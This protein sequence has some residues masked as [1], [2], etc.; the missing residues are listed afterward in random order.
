M[1]AHTRH[2]YPCGDDNAINSASSA[3][4]NGNL[5]GEGRIPHLF[6]LASSLFARSVRTNSLQDLEDA[7]A[8][9]RGAVAQYPSPDS[10]SSLLLYILAECLLFRFEILNNSSDLQEGLSLHRQTLALRPSNHAAHYRSQ[11]SLA[12]AL[13][14][15][16]NH[17]GDYPRLV[18]A[19]D[20]GCAALSLFD[21]L[22]H[23]RP[24]V[25]D[26]IAKTF[27]SRFN[28]VGQPPDLPAQDDAPPPLPPSKAEKEWKRQK[29]VEKVE[30]ESIDAIMEMTGLEE[31]KAQVLRIKAKIDTAERQGVSMSDEQFNIVLRGNPGTGKTTIARHYARFLASVGILSED[32]FFETTGSRLAND[33]VRGIKDQLEEMLADDGGAV[34]IDEAYQLTNG[35]SAGGRQVL[36]FLLAEME[37]HIGKLVFIFAGYNKQMETFFEHNPGLASRVPYSLQFADYTDA[38]LLHMLAKLIAKRYNGR[39]VI[40]GGTYGLY[41]RIAVRRLGRGRGTEGFGNARALRTMFAKICER[42][43]MRL[44]EMRQTGAKPDDFLF[45]KEDIIGPDPSEALLESASWRKLH[46]LVGL[47]EV[48]QN[49][50]NLFE[51]I[52]E[53]YKRELAEKKPIQMSLNRVF[54]GNPGTGKTTVAKLYGQIL[55]DIGLLSNGEVVLKNPAD[56]IGSALGESEKNTKAILAAT[57][58][59]VLVIDE[60]YSLYGNSAGD[61]SRPSDDYRTSVIDVLVAQIQSVPGEDR[62]VLMCGYEAQMRTMFQNVNPGLSGRFAIEDAFRFEDYTD[63]ELLQIMD[64]KLQEQDLDASDDAKKVALDMLGRARNRPNFGNGREVENI[65]GKAKNNYRSRVSTFPASQRPFDVVFESADFDPNFDRAD[66]SDASLQRLFN[67]MIGVETIVEKLREYQAIPRV[68]KQR[69]QDSRQLIPTNFIFKGPPGSGKTTVARRMGQVY[70][71]MGFLSSAELIECSV[72]DLAGQ[73]V[74]HTGP[75]AKQVF[76]RA[77]GKVLLIDD[78]HRFTDSAYCQEAMNELVS[79]LGQS[80]QLV[81]ILAGDGKKMDA[82]LSANSTLANRVQETIHFPPFSPE[83]C[84]EI[85]RKDL[86]KNNIECAALDATGSDE[87]QYMASQIA[88]LSAQP[89]WSN[90]HDL[91]ALSQKLIR[92]TFKQAA[93]V[94]GEGDNL[95]LS[96]AGAA[97]CIAD[98][99]SERAPRPPSPPPTSTSTRRRGHFSVRAFEMEL[100]VGGSSPSSPSPVPASQPETYQAQAEASFEASATRHQEQQRKRSR[101]MAMEDEQSHQETGL[102]DTAKEQRAQKKLKEMALCP[103]GFEWTKEG[104]GYRCKGGS[105]FVSNAQLGM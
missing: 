65:L 30:S 48:K 59:K 55:A 71:D 46:Q 11:V 50:Q 80:T 42:Q 99:V 7:I 84:L 44:A 70:Y 21:P 51:L 61:G 14:T 12:K 28:S 45:T 60:A 68:S 90:G 89:S 18:E 91:K 36:D 54:L 29:T 94:K 25:L 104:G 5:V 103:Q 82:L 86:A 23:D 74:G 67:D 9:A 49:I 77:L 87:Y 62:C 24:A 88:Q 63:P 16:Y 93:G 15:F 47:S 26:D 58:G 53:N 31:V 78:A 75:K 32:T 95:W 8:A 64:R 27:Y 92:F 20:H 66:S 4:A 102:Q 37:N 13:H 35:H 100:G 73:Y 81:V 97:S 72:S 76:Q 19:I 34:F 10:H 22:R 79:F 56:F 98:V 96:G 57:V 52:A 1:P 105:H 6:T 85:I 3:L 83:Q 38:E 69:G 101:S 40:E 41:M 17:T 43:A 39:M 33:G 2:P